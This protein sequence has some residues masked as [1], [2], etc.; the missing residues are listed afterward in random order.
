MIRFA[1][2]CC[3]SAGL[4][5]ASAQDKSSTPP[6]N[7]PAAIAGTV[8]FAEGDATIDNA[9][10]AR[11]AK[12]GDQVRV[13]ETITTFPKAEVHLKMA[14]GAYFS[15]RENSKITITRYRANGD[16]SD[17][18]LVDLAK[19]AMRAVTGWIGRYKRENYKVRTP[20]V[21]IGVRG[22]DHEPT[23]LLEGDPRGEPGS[24]DKVNEGATVMDSPKGRVEVKPN[25]AAHFHTSLAAPRTLPSVP[26]FFQPSKNE[27]RF[28]QRAQASVKTIDTQRDDRRKARG[29]PSQK[30]GTADRKM[31][32]RVENKNPPRQGGQLQRKMEERRAQQTPRR[33]EKKAAEPRRTEKRQ[34]HFEK[35]K[36]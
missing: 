6:A 1:L 13:G 21:T 9:G 33:F 8:D 36:R 22:T 10:T 26:K 35:K 28:T 19:G 17:E 7:A 2:F 15:L 27:A 4:L 14:D 29:L 31:E 32:N 5:T 30:S 34:E 11:L 24:Y 3:L 20:M 16:D 23:H 25:T 12:E 18:S